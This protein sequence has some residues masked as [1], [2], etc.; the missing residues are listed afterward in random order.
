MSY[1]RLSAQDASFLH[2]EQEHQPMHVG[3]LGVFEAGPLLDHAGRF[4]LDD[5]RRE[6]ARRLHLV[7]RFRKKLMTVPYGQGRPVWVDD[8]AFDLA[9]HVR[10]TA[11]PRP[12]DEEQLKALMNRLQSQTL[13]RRRPLWELWFVEGLAGERVAIIQKTHHALVDGISGVDVATVLLD[14]E[15][16][17]PKADAPDWEPHK[18]PAPPQLLAESLWER[19]TQPAEMVRSMR[20]AMRGPRRLA[21]QA[22]ER[23]S[24][25]SRLVSAASTTAPEMPWN[26]A[27]TPHRRF[28]MARVPLDVAKAVKNA[29]GCTLNDVVLAAVTGGLRIFLESRGLDVDGVT[30]KAMCPVSVRD[31]SERMA[32]GNRVS[33]MIVELPVGEADPAARLA[34]IGT[35]TREVKESGMAVAAEALIGLGDYAPPTLLS[36]GARLAS[37]GRPVNLGITNVPGPQIPLYCLGARMLEAFP[38][39]GIIDNQG[40]MVAVLSYDG[41]LSFGLTSDRDLLPDLDVLAEGIEKSFTELME[42]V[43]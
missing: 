40:L 29:A 33:A 21:E 28:E 36:L 17:P 19:A 12:G 27:V 23:A 1:D 4:R 18:A 13:D 43:S 25:V 15:P 14:L 39:V 20:A 6:I 37:V 3:S 22:A 2:V 7:P 9:Y 30:L 32:L 16:S 26:A 34:A 41:Q 10:L 31:D 42:K 11:L 38:Y 35:H 8:E 5:A 24:Q